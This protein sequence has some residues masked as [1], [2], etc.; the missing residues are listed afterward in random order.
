MNLLTSDPLHLHCVGNVDAF[1]L[2][3]LMWT[4]ESVALVVECVSGGVPVVYQFT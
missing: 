4:F 2:K 3:L 1:T